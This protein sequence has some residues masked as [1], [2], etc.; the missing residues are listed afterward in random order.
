[1]AQSIEGGASA[2]LNQ[3]TCKERC[4]KCLFGYTLGK[5]KSSA[6][7]MVGAM[8]MFGSLSVGYSL[9]KMDID[10]FARFF[11]VAACAITEMLSLMV[12]VLGR[13]GVNLNKLNDEKDTTIQGLR[14]EK[15]DLEK[16][17]EDLIKQ[18]AIVESLQGLNEDA[19]RTL[20]GFQMF[21]REYI[22]PLMQI[23]DGSSRGASLS[24][25]R[26]GSSTPEAQLRLCDGESRAGAAVGAGSGNADAEETKEEIPEDYRVEQ[27]EDNVVRQTGCGCAA[28]PPPRRGAQ[29]EIIGS[30]TPSPKKAQPIEGDASPGAERRMKIEDSF[31]VGSDREGSNRRSDVV[32]EVASGGGAAADESKV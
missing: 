1:M 11:G 23:L 29:E 12:F 17:K 10:R 26:L 31:R 30:F 2:A 32:V 7:S 22:G 5:T 25:H 16:S 13:S 14:D 6:L 20:N 28:Q 27:L 4:C 9:Y 15:K 19:K 8:A 24:A 3:L 18:L 21:G